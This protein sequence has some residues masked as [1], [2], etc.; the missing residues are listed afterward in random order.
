MA[1]G[2][3]K[4]KPAKKR[5]GGKRPNKNVHKNAHKNARKGGQ[6]AKPK[7]KGEVSLQQAYKLRDRDEKKQADQARR[8]KQAEDRRRREINQKIRA[9]VKEHSL[10]REDA[11]HS[12]NFLYKGRIRKVNVTGEQ[13]KKLNAGELGLVYL[14]GGYHL[15]APEPLEEVRKLSPDHVPDLTSGTDEA[16]EE[17]PVP[18]DITW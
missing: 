14:T 1:L 9:I 10:S 2:L 17:F 5:G 7:T 12:R 11:E 4:K 15:L 6:S 16:E 13:L 18:D 8:R 3:A